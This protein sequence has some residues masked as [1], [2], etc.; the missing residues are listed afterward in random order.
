MFEASGLVGFAADSFV[1]GDRYAIP[2]T[3]PFVYLL[4]PLCLPNFYI[5]YEKLG[6][7]P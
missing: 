7:P 5:T 6:L 4:T 3:P 2:Y 1:L